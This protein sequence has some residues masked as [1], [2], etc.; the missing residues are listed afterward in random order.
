MT[1]L[2]DTSFVKIQN[3]FFVDKTQSTAQVES[4]SYKEGLYACQDLGEEGGPFIDAQC[5][6]CLI[7]AANKRVLLF[8]LFLL[9]QDKESCLLTYNITFYLS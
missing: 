7:T 8:T 6:G 9:S 2:Q 3:F 4:D 1:L 5:W